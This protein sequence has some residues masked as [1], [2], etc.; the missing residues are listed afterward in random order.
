MRLAGL[1]GVGGG[2]LGGRDEHTLHMEE[3]E[4][5]PSSGLNRADGHIYVFI[6]PHRL[7]LQSDRSPLTRRWDLCFIPLN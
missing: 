2:C 6:P 5:W 1:V 3:Y 7:F 4:L